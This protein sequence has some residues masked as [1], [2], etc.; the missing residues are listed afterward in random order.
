MS[1]RLVSKSL[2]PRTLF[3]WVGVLVAAAILLAFWLGT[4]MLF[5]AGCLTLLAFSV[6]VVQS[7]LNLRRTLHRRSAVAEALDLLPHASLL[8]LVVAL[9]Y[10]IVREMLSR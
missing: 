6:G 9:L 8:A 7:A 5:V 10:V 4:K 2:L 3:Q 1:E